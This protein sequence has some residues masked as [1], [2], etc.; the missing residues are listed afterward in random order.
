LSANI[1][2]TPR[3]VA[4]YLLFH[5]GTGAQILPAGAPAGM[6]EALDFACRTVRWFSPGPVA[7]SLDLGCAVG[8]STYELARASELTVGIDF[9]AAFIGAARAVANRPLVV[10]RHDEGPLVTALEISLPQGL[11][12]DGVSFEVGDALDLR[13]D[14]GEFDRVHAA[15]LLCR[16]AEPNRLLDR[17][18]ALVR[19][20]GELVLATPCTWLEEFTPRPNWPAGA[21]LDWLKDNLGGAFELAAVGDEPF[22]IRETA[23]KFQWTR[24]QLTRWRRR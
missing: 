6:E 14:L 15:N 19:G 5:Y 1:Y 4:E 10:E 16:L 11:C 13:A 2:E 8:R 23:R 7:R 12:A 9:S 3:L 18:P 20:G 22:L 24:A 21:T 17:L